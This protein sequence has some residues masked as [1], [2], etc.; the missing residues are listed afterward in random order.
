[1]D[2]RDRQPG[3]LSFGYDGE[4]R[5]GFY[6]QANFNVIDNDSLRI[7][8]SP[9]YL[10]QKAFTSSSAVSTSNPTGS[11]VSFASPSAFGL[12]STV[13]L[14]LNN[15]LSFY[16][17]G[18]F[19]SLEVDKIGDY[20]RAQLQLRQTLGDVNNPYDLRFQYN[21]RER[22]FNGSQG[23]QTVDSSYGLLLV[24]PF[25]ILGDSQILFYYQASI[26]NISAPTDRIDLLPVNRT[27]NVLNLTRYQGVLS[28]YRTFSLWENPALPPTPEEGL[29]YTPV[30]IQ[31]Y[32]KVTFGLSSVT[33]F[34]STGDTQ[35][36]LLGSVRLFGQFGHF[37]RPFLDYTGFDL[38]L[39]QGIRG[40]LSPFYFDRF[41]DTQVVTLGLTQQIY[42]PVRLGVQTSYSITAN[43][44]ISTDF[45]LEYSRRTYNLLLRYNPILQLGSINLRISDFNWNGNPGRFEG[46]DV[47]PVIQ[48]VTRQD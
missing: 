27:D 29:K 16:A 9:Q 30:P 4:D 47:R 17:K 42:G 23:Y 26:Q 37:S 21:Y 2:R 31:P 36:S 5:G 43:R 48:G 19:S 1:M 10:L 18:S 14:T 3:L 20:T 39:S 12:V 40:D 8:V 6:V 32:I 15:R 45:F 35:P 13:D 34:Y 38:T 44:E 41:V 46:S 7:Q 33:N 25:F 22:L 28:F 11:D 24:S